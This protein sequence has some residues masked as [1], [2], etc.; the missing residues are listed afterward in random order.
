MKRPK[1]FKIGY[2]FGDF[3]LVEPLG[4]GQDGEVWKA[5]KLS[6]GKQGQEVAIKFLNIVD[7]EDK[8]HRFEREIDALAQLSHPNIVSI[9]ESGT[10][11]NPR[12]KKNVPYYIMEYI[13]GKP[14]KKALIKLPSDDLSRAIFTFLEQ[15]FSALYKIHNKKLTHG[16]IKSANILVLRENMIAKIVDFGFS[17]FSDE[18]RNRNDYPPTSHHVPSELDSEQAD[19]H[20][21]GKTLMDCLDSLTSPIPQKVKIHLNSL[22]EDLLKLPAPPAQDTKSNTINHLRQL[23][24]AL[25]IQ[26]IPELRQ[27][28]DNITH[29]Y[30]PFHGNVPFSFRAMAII[31]SPPLQHLRNINAFPNESLV[32]PSLSG[33]LFEVIIGEYAALRKALSS[34]LDDISISEVI[35]DSHLDLLFFACLIRRVSQLPFEWLIEKSKQNTQDK[36]DR[37][38]SILQEEPLRYI[39]AEKWNLNIKKIRD[40]LFSEPYISYDSP[41]SILSWFLEDPLAPPKIESMRKLLWGCGYSFPDINKLYPNITLAE[42]PIDPFHKLVVVVKDI[43]INIIEE[44]LQARHYLLN[45]ILNNETVIAANLMLKK[46]FALIEKSGFDFNSLYGVSDFEFLNGCH[47]TARRDGIKTACYLIKEYQKRHIFKLISSFELPQHYGILRQYSEEM[48]YELKNKL[49]R[50]ISTFK[51]IDENEIIIDFDEEGWIRDIPIMILKDGIVIQAEKASPVIGSIIDRIAKSNNN[52]VK[53]YASKR[54]KGNLSGED[55]HR[56]SFLL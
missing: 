24:K 12:I 52:K 9:R 29:I 50:N 51:N 10:T 49:M 30:D 41:L 32:F 11:R 40:L 27:D 1:D 35:T 38:T 36:Y 39:L 46:A 18:I 25:P 15:I 20:R 6:V 31:D 23:E 53:V 2:K 17:L 42:N 3:K 43:A 54:V 33:S 37:I 13:D 48:R 4:S 5:R 8:L 26:V 21:L 47:E 19:F 28:Y 34:T 22:I 45:R 44:I 56:I 7:D 14:L 55:Q 16:D